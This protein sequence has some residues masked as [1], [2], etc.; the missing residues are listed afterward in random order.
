[1]HVYTAAS[2]QLPILPGASSPA[3]PAA[4][5]SPLPIAATASQLQLSIQQSIAT[6]AVIPAKL[7]LA[8]LATLSGRLPTIVQT[9]S[10]VDQPAR[11][12]KLQPATGPTTTP[13]PRLRLGRPEELLLAV[14]CAKRIAEDPDH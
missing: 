5:R 13:E 12:T 11:T 14:C 4:I 9:V 3:T 7:C 8:E 10:P 1:M 2:I 6:A